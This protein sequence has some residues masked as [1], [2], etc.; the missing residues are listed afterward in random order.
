M[1]TAQSIKNAPEPARIRELYRS[2]FPKEEQMPWGLMKFLSRFPDID[3]TGY[4]RADAFCGMTFTVCHEQ[5][6]FVLFLAVDAHSRG[7]GNGSAI[8]THLKASHPG[9]T[10]LLNVELLEEDA[11]NLAQRIRRMAF[12]KKN[13][14]Y[15]TGYNIREVGGWFRVLAT[16]PRPDM[17]AYRRVFGKMSLG[18]WRPP[19]KKV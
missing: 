4:Y 9:K 1:I 12:Y 2:A 16:D 6:L 11:P 3:L 8:L 13:G 19:I 10:I 14:F 7:R 15:D 18:L 17:E 5:I